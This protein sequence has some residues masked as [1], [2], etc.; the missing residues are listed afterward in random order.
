[1]VLH[2]KRFTT[3]LSGVQKVNTYVPTPLE[4]RCFCESC[5]KTEK[6]KTTP[7]KY[8]LSCVIMHLGASMASGHY[9]AYSR[10]AVSIHFPRV[11]FQ[12]KNVLIDSQAETCDYTDCSRDIPKSYLGSSSKEMSANILKFFK[13]KAL[14]NSLSENQNGV[15]SNS[16]KN[17]S[18]VIQFLNIFG[19]LQNV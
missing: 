15:G 17:D 18:Q 4:I 10:A 19:Y 5:S 1:M 13:A 12:K 7:H 11:T 3:S 8:Q 16:K 2:L 6:S 14:G 9:I